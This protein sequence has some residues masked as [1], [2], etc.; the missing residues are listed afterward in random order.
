MLSQAA[1]RAFTN[2]LNSPPKTSNSIHCAHEYPGWW[3]RGLAPPGINTQAESTVIT[4]LGI[5]LVTHRVF[6]RDIY[7]HRTVTK[8]SLTD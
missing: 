7:N 3:N 2:T 4:T 1:G 5:H 8:R 6:P